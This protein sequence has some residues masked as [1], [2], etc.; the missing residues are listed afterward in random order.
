MLPDEGLL[1]GQSDYL[2]TSGDWQ[3]G[4]IADNTWA[5]AAGDTFAS[6]SAIEVTNTDVPGY[7]QAVLGVADTGPVIVGLNS[8]TEWLTSVSFTCS[9]GDPPTPFTVYGWFLY[10]PTDGFVRA[11]D[12]LRN[13][14]GTPTPYTFVLDGDQLTIPLTNIFRNP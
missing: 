11:A 14:G 4:L 3:V 9:G 7:V 10:R 5:P 1:Q 2:A 13:S 8:E 6:L 12:L